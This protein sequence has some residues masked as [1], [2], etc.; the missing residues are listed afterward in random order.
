MITLKTI[1]GKP[2][3]TIKGRKYELKSLDEAWYVAYT[4]RFLN[5]R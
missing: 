4:L 1:K 3:L 5:K 2:I